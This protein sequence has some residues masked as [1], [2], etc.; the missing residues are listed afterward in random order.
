MPYTGIH[1]SLRVYKDGYFQAAGGETVLPFLIDCECFVVKNRS[2]LFRDLDFYINTD[3]KVV[4][5]TPATKDDIFFI[6]NLSSFT[7]DNTATKQDIAAVTPPLFEVVWRASRVNLPQGLIPADGQTLQ[8]SMFPDVVDS[9]VRGFVPTVDEA[10]WLADPTKRGCYSLGNGS[11]TFRVPDYNGKQ[12]DATSAPFL[13]GDGKNS[14]SIGVVQGDAIRNITYSHL[15]APYHDFGWS[16]IMQGTR[17]AIDIKT[18]TGQGMSG[19]RFDSG[20]TGST[21]TFDASRVVPTSNE[22]RPVNVAGVWCIR[23]FNGVVNTGVWDA[24]SL[25]K[26]LEALEATTDKTG[27]IKLFENR[28]ALATRSSQYLPMD[29]QVLNRSDEP[30]LVAKILD[31][32]LPSC[33]DADWLA[34]PTKRG[35]YTLG[36]GTTTFRLPDRNGK[37]S[38]SLG[39]LFPRGDGKNA[40]VNGAI[41]GDA[42][43]NITGAYATRVP[44]VH[45]YFASG[46]FSGVNSVGQNP[47]A[48]YSSMGTSSWSDPQRYGYNFDAS[49][50]VPTAVENRPVG[51][52][53]VWTVKR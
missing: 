30:N 9:I 1:P 48:E 39:A 18:N 37:L 41:Q 34:D 51:F 3:N 28:K 8:R 38:D 4:L 21:V 13:R 42:I 20:A 31:G 52:S 25:I 32:T 14:A 29:G 33:S 44:N 26:R 50:V 17:G 24:D 35:N 2:I 46:A 5:N 6:V 19:L 43:R 27:D 16:G 40:P 45:A 11:T 7:F 23:L 22:N 36:N 12:P 53:I 10:T 49:R 47:V 15:L